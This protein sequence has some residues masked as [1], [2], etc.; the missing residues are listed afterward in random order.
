MK[1]ISMKNKARASLIIVVL[2]CYTS[3]SFAQQSG[4]L[5]D[6]IFKMDSLFSSAQN[7]CDL[8]RY[9]SFLSE[10]FEYFHDKAGFTDSKEN[11]MAV[12]N[13][14]GPADIASSK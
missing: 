1:S 9:E 8:E 12:I 6:E 5:Y 3:I 11:E 7:D 4:S 13:S 10:D 14:N 2:T